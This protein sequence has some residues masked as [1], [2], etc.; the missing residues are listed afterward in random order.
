MNDDELGYLVNS[1]LTD[2]VFFKEEQVNI[3]N[4]YKDRE[5]KTFA[6]YQMDEIDINELNK[7]VE[8]IS[9]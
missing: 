7:A 9:A 2:R 4:G 5:I 8:E 6:Q 3:L 1:D